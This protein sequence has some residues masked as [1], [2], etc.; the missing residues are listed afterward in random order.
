LSEIVRSTFESETRARVDYVSVTDAE[1]L[2]KVDKLDERAVL[3]AVAIYI[4][5]TRLIDNTVLN[6]SKKKDGVTAK[7]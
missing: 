3:I 6:S 4:G 5:K 2:E 7:A 1:T